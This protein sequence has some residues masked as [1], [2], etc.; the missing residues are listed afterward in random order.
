[1]SSISPSQACSAMHSCATIDLFD[2]LNDYMNL[3]TNNNNNNTATTT[4]TTTNGNDSSYC[5]T[6]DNDDNSTTNNSSSNNSVFTSNIFGGSNNTTAM[7]A[8]AAA[9]TTTTSKEFPE[10]DEGNGSFL[11]LFYL[12]E[13]GSIDEIMSFLGLLECGYFGAE[14]DINTRSDS[15]Y[16]ALHIACYSNRGD[17]VE[18]LLAHGADPNR[19]DFKQ[20][21][22]L[23]LSV[24]MN[25]EQAFNVLTGAAASGATCL[26]P[27]IADINGV[28][29]L[30]LACANSLDRMVWRLLGLGASPSS[31]SS[32]SSGN[33]G[34]SPLYAAAKTGN[35]SVVRGLL[36][37]GAD[38]N[39]ALGN[40]N[41][42]LIAAL[43]GSWHACA[44]TLL[45]AGASAVQAN[46]AGVTPLH[47]ALFVGDEDVAA[48]LLR[49]G[50]GPLCAG[51]PD[52]TGVTPLHMAVSAGRGDLA[53]CFLEECGADPNASYGP[54]STPL[55]AAVCAG[56]ADMVALLLAHGADPNRMTAAGLTPLQLAARDNNSSSSRGT[57]DMLVVLLEHGADPCCSDAIGTTPL[58]VVAATGRIVAIKA[59]LARGADFAARTL[60]GD[61]P[62][63]IAVEHD[64]A[65]VVE[66]LLEAAAASSSSSAV[67]Q[68]MAPNGRGE[69]P[70]LLAARIGSL[71]VLEALLPYAPDLDAASKNGDYPLLAAARGGFTPVMEALLAHG[72]TIPRE[73]EA[74][75][76]PLWHVSANGNIE[77]VE[78]LLR[79]GS[80]PSPYVAVSRNPAI[81]MLLVMNGAKVL[82]REWT[83]TRDSAPAAPL[84][85]LVRSLVTPK[86]DPHLFRLPALGCPLGVLRNTLKSLG[87]LSNPDVY[88]AA[89][90][91]IFVN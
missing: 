89:D 28:T 57:D 8:A 88:L 87:E 34:A 63:L 22:P 78:L 4:T 59:L 74:A 43:E 55:Y 41:T 12:C 49:R 11:D 1:M 70:A 39:E 35:A 47:M 3:N 24:K 21:T 33:F 76:G 19:Q 64:H 2:E 50:A 7:P 54:A 46:R 71:P 91:S 44:A 53:R 51:C 81:T 9:A 29:P 52:Q 27:D 61:T 90:P 40:G 56:R 72:V 23:L 66:I 14:V 68:A 31:S 67:A 69:T 83:A 32:S 13:H 65:E 62:L 84:H 17:V 75:L 85:A 77:A 45:A 6:D 58:H 37:V 48:E 15:G 38:P 36:R 20:G 80:D 25:S 18:A 10:E 60:V 26:D 82:P 86:V 16:T 5:N 79:Y 42:P 30:F 73:N